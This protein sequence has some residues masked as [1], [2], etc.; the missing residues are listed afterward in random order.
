MWGAFTCRRF[1]PVHACWPA[2]NVR[3]RTRAH[4]GQRKRWHVYIET[5][6][7]AA[8]AA[9]FVGFVSVGMKSVSFRRMF[10]SLLSVAPADVGGV[11]GVCAVFCGSVNLVMEI[12]TPGVGRQQEPGQT[13]PPR[14]DMDVTTV[15]SA[16]WSHDPP[17][18]QSK[19]QTHHITHR[20]LHQS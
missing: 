4:G 20:Q 11:S 15:S 1:L 8:A 16:D 7:R 13:H 19:T 2:W 9:A 6:S 17:P 18:L 3:T 5:I 10:W 14:A 12:K